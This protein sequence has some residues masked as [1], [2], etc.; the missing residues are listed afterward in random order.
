MHT[1]FSMSIFF[2]VSDIT[3]LQCQP[4][5]KVAL[6]IFLKKHKNIPPYVMNT[7]NDV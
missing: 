6:M 1:F 2:K 5:Q 3:F 7:K 4:L